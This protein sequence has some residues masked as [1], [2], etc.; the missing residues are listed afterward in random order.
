MAQ[1]TWEI[2]KMRY[3]THAGCE[4]YLEAEVIYPAEWLPDTPPRVNAHRCSHAMLC[5]FDERA[6]CVWSGTNPAVDPF[7]D[8][9]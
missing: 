9:G 3:C 8:K 4:V 5:N 7:L 6:S 2:Y 1:K